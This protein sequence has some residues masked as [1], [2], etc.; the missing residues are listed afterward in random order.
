MYLYLSY[1]YFTYAFFVYVYS[2]IWIF[3]SCFI[4]RSTYVFA[5]FLRL[6]SLFQSLASVLI[7]V[8]QPWIFL[9]VFCRTRRRA[10]Y[11]YIE[12]TPTQNTQTRTQE[13]PTQP[14]QG[15][16]A[17]Q[18]ADTP[19]LTTKKLSHTALSLEEGNPLSSSQE[20][21]KSFLPGQPNGF[22]AFLFLFF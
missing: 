4:V 7:R 2:L 10:V 11:H 6:F 21:Q 12:K 22:W 8:V 13:N 3:F 17:C 16:S 19:T 14:E 18:V 1:T 20:P 15:Q 5:Y 9:G